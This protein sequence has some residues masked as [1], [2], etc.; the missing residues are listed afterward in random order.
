MRW[1]MFL[2]PFALIGCGSDDD[3][4]D[5]P[6][7]AVV[8]QAAQ[9]AYIYGY[10]LVLMERT[11]QVSTAVSHAEGSRA[12]M[13][14]W[15][16]VRGFPD[17]SFK[18]VVSPNVDTLYS[19][20]WLDLDAEPL[21]ISV[22]DAGDFAQLGASATSGP[23]PRYYLLQMLDAWTNVFDSP[24]LR[25]RGPEARDFLLSGPGWQGTVPE[26]L[27]HIASPTDM[28]W[29]TGRTQVL[30][31]QDLPTVHAFQNWILCPGSRPLPCVKVTCWAA[32]G[33]S[34]SVPTL[35]ASL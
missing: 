18:D 33:W 11:R 35:V 5:P 19:I 2:L 27:E 3:H 34:F 4:Q 20:A 32:P 13:N 16:H 9:D 15:A 14:Q 31:M 10:P 21:V 7:A 26:G 12:P 25:T 8:R 23:E 28:V 29:I 22:P 24:G 17:P 6:S 1:P 30:D